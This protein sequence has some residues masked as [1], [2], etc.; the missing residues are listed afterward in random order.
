LPC[1]L[2]CHGGSRVIPR[3]IEAL[4]GTPE[5]DSVL[6]VEG[7]NRGTVVPKK[8]WTGLDVNAVAF[9][10]SKKPGLFD[11][12]SVNSIS[13]KSKARY[14]PYT[15]GSLSNREIAT[16]SNPDVNHE[17]SSPGAV[18]AQSGELP[19]T[20]SG[21]STP[22][23]TASANAIEGAAA[24]RGTIPQ[25]LRPGASATVGKPVFGLTKPLDRK[26]TVPVTPFLPKPLPG[27]P[28]TL[29]FAVKADEKGRR[30]AKSALRRQT[31]L[32]P[33]AGRINESFGETA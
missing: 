15:A 25:S 12:A 24:T 9:R 17:S 21:P 16:T 27:T 29:Q 13:T 32:G 4:S 3:V 10:T 23:E 6:V 1:R 18:P 20:P 5:V 11:S 30:R 33:A 31:V 7:T 22:P 8:T 19:S 2:P 28:R 26:R 14:E